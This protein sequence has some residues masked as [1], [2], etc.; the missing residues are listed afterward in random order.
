MVETSNG[1]LYLFRLICFYPE[2]EH[3]VRHVRFYLRFNVN[4]KNLHSNPLLLSHSI[5]KLT[6]YA[7]YDC[8]ITNDLV[9]LLW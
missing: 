7:N 1:Q 5:H 4:A 2:L 9:A 6:A 8:A 3:L